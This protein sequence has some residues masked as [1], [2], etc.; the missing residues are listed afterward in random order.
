MISS[1]IRVDRPLEAAQIPS[2][3]VAEAI[4]EV[5]AVTYK[6][7]VSRRG[8]E[9]LQLINAKN[10][11]ISIKVKPSLGLTTTGDAKC[12]QLLSGEFVVY[13]GDTLEDGTL[14]D[15]PWLTFGRIPDLTAREPLAEGAIANLL[16][17]KAMVA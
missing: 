15:T 14:L 16:K 13:Y 10:E 1:A 11:R 5:K 6:L 8:N 12:R 17:S 9:Y 7:V 3:T 2:A 4:K